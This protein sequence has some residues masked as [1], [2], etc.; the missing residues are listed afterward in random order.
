MPL[1][2]GRH[3]LKRLYDAIVQVR[4]N[5]RRCRRLGGITVVVNQGQPVSYPCVQ[6]GSNNALRMNEV[7][8]VRG[9][10]TITMITM[11]IVLYSIVHKGNDDEYEWGGLPMTMTI[12][13]V[14]DGRQHSHCIGSGTSSS[15][16]QI[17]LCR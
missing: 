5:G 4:C 6:G 15:V 10:L 16:Q 12:V 1:H 7:V 17:Y 9:W 13:E 3:S 14:I 2:S 8:V 11:I